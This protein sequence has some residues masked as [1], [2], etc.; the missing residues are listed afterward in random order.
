MKWLP[1]HSSLSVILIACI[2]LYYFLSYEAFLISAGLVLLGFIQKTLG[3]WIHLSWMYLA[4][5]LGRIN[6]AILLFLLYFLILTPAAWIARMLGKINM[7]KD[8]KK[9]QT[10]FVNRNHRYSEEDLKFL[11]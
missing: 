10:S 11:W 8:F 3:E 6:S 5:M 4:R 9:Q 7:R 1:R 2:L